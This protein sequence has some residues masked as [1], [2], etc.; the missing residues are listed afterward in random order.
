MTTSASAESPASVLAFWF[1]DAPERAA[2]D[3]TRAKLW[4]SKQPAVDAQMRERFAGL[5]DDVGAGLLDGWAHTDLGRLALILVAD[6]F[7]RNIHRGTPRSFGLDPL[8]RQWTLHGLES[9]A[10]EALLPIQRLFAYMPLEHSE[11]LEHQ[12]RCVAL[13]QG[14]RDRATPEEAATFASYAD[15]A[16]KHRAVIQRFGRFPH[17]NAILG[18]DSTAEELAFLQTPGSSF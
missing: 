11:S 18:R 7:S 13:M 2:T 16:E 10:F 1:G 14:L 17:R 3:P 12:D 6:Q 5:V 4:W 8:A 15:Y 9:G